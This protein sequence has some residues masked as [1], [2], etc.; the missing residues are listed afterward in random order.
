[1]HKD[2]CRNV[3]LYLSPLDKHLHQAILTMHT[4]WPIFFVVIVRPK[5]NR[6]V[7]I[8]FTL[9]WK[10][11][12]HLLK[13]FGPRGLSKQIGGNF[14]PSF[15]LSFPTPLPLEDPEDTCIVQ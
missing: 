13:K 4:L 3:G 8:S 5:S 7:E 2:I 12:S 1:M 14:P 15:R 11:K 6:F 9:N 10:V